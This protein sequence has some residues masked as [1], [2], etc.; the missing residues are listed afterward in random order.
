MAPSLSLTRRSTPS[1]QVASGSGSGSGC[2]EAPASQSMPA[3]SR[4]SWPVA[5]VR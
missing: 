3:W 1:S 5:W 2:S 4:R